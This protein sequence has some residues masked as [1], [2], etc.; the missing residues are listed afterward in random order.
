MKLLLPPTAIPFA[1]EIPTT[2]RSRRRNFFRMCMLIYSR[3][4]T[5]RRTSAFSCNRKIASCHYMAAITSTLLITQHRRRA[6]INTIFYHNRRHL[7]S[8]SFDFRLKFNLSS[9]SKTKKIYGSTKH[10]N[11]KPS[12]PQLVSW[13]Y[14]LS[15]PFDVRE[16]PGLLNYFVYLQQILPCFLPLIHSID[17]QHS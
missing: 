13:L 8:R 7:A 9:L 3:C 10:R 17:E 2:V 4:I 1:H 11:I 16:Q 14:H 15:A 5:T 12:L 6:R